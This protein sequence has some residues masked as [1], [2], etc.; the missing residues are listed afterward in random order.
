M[1][2]E[3][4]QQLNVLFSAALARPAPERA[5]FLDEAC[6][7]D[8]ELQQELASLL[9]HHVP[10]EP[11]I[12]ALPAAVAAELLA[13][14]TAPLF[15]GGMIRHYRMLSRWGRGGWGEVHL[16]LDTQL[17]RKVAIKL[18]TPAH[19][20]DAERV[21]RF[22]QEARAASA[23][24]HPNILTVH[25]IGVTPTTEGEAHY[26]VSEFVAGETLRALITRGSLD[27]KQTVAI[28]EQ[29]AQALNAAHE[30]GII[31][32]DIKPENVMV[33]PDGLV[34]VLDFGIAKLTERQEDGETERRRAGDT[35][36]YV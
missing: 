15:S 14:D 27:V 17:G 26:I 30:A 23:L 36:H 13:T 22:A 7:Q 6:A 9:A 16:A 29:V 19:T 8:A 5:A 10:A 35:E 20:A 18:L 3:R 12:T 32:R 33:R 34:K 4:W 2:P 25:E 24:S 11:F 31:H 28:A 21:R 1:T